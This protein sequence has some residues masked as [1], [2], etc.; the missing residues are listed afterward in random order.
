MKDVV[1]AKR[2][3]AQLIVPRGTKVCMTLGGKRSVKEVYN[4]CQLADE[5]M[6]PQLGMHTQIFVEV[7]IFSTSVDPES[8]VKRFFSN[9]PVEAYS[10]LEIPIPNQ[11]TD[12]L[13][14]Y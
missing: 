1:R 6:M 7:N 2:K 14:L 4:L 12:D 11:D 9:V 13:N 8:D 10:S 5:F 3:T